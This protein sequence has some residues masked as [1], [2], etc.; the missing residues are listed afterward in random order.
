MTDNQIFEPAVLA[1]IKLKNRIIRSATHEGLADGNGIPTEALKIKY[2]QL[3]KG[4]VGA[5]ITGY[6]GIRQ[7]GKSPNYQM[8][9][10]DTED[11]IPFYRDIVDAVHEHGTP[12]IQQLAH[13]G[14]QTRSKVTGEKPV[15]PSAIRDKMFLEE[16]PKE[17]SDH[18]IRDIINNFIDAIDR[19]KKAG[20]DGVQL[21]I[22]HGYLLAQF[23]SPYSNR[24]KDQWGGSMENRYRI[25]DEIFQG[26]RKRVG[27]F[28]I[29][30]K[31]NAYDGR[32]NGMRIDEAVHIAGLLEKSGC[33]AI[34][35]S[36]G[37]IED[38]FYASRGEKA[39]VDAVLEY[40][41]LFRELNPVIKFMARPLVR[42]MLRSD[43]KP[44][45]NYNVAAAQQIKER[46][47][48]PVIVVGGIKSLEDIADII[49]TQKTDFVSM[50]RPFI[51]EPNLV[52]K[53]KEGTR[54]ESRC[55]HCNYCSIAQEAQSLRCYYGKI[56]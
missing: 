29:L 21:H 6:A 12:I 42:F 30:V 8:L 52:K 28:P 50:C 9:M 44:I 10:M 32:K 37:T 55:I 36:C 26:A 17:L 25:I 27:S 33:A 23:L 46:V 1:G 18:E 24:R 34:E 4:E 3:A 41:Y 48:I 11:Y 35:V 14:R 2:L 53:F 56:K 16:V 13:C 38:G 20:F 5:I 22:A 49:G 43:P 40:S 31:M 15:A 7:N 39:P 47:S 54:K 45:Y 51:I 19:S